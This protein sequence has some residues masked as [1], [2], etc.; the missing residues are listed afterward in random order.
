M[1]VP[2]WKSHTKFLPIRLGNMV[3]I[4]CS[5][6]GACLGV[7]WRQNDKDWNPEDKGN[8]KKDKEERNRIKW[9][10]TGLRLVSRLCKLFCTRL[11]ALKLDIMLMELSIDFVGTSTSGQISCL[12][13]YNLFFKIIFCL[14]NAKV[15]L[16]YYIPSCALRLV[17]CGSAAVSIEVPQYKPFYTIPQHR[18]PFLFYNS[19]LF[20][21]CKPTSYS[22]P[23]LN[24]Q[25]RS[26][27]GVTK[28]WVK[29]L[30]SSPKKLIADIYW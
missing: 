30:S 23:S 24:R 9:N 10:K 22:I 12:Y 28:I 4:I 2:F 8:R 27:V 20:I 6:P 11:I 29:G 17:H 19:T 15:R 7:S 16:F 18:S 13:L 1:K 25:N 14:L 3:W 26:A 5:V 21:Y